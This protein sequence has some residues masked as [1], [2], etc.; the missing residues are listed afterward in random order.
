MRNYWI[1]TIWRFVEGDEKYCCNVYLK[2]QRK[3]VPK[4]GDVVFFRESISTPKQVV[5]RIFRG[6]E[7]MERVGNGCGGIIAAA[8]VFEHPTNI[9]P[10]PDWVVAYDFG[11]LR[12]WTRVIRCSDHRFKN[13]M[14]WG[15]LRAALNTKTGKFLNLYKLKDTTRDLAVINRLSNAIG[16]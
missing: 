15:E 1:S 3:T 7:S 10:Y 13:W 4:I 6:E 11:D 12:E 9:P 16:L 14:S 2:E 8:V 5:R